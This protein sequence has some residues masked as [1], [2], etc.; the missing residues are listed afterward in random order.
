MFTGKNKEDL[1]YRTLG[2]VGFLNYSIYENGVIVNLNTG[3]ER[4][5]TKGTRYPMVTLYNRGKVKTFSIHRLLALM[6]ID[7]PDNL[8]C[9][10]HLDDNKYNYDLSNLAWGTHAE[11][12]KDAYDSGVKKYHNK[13]MPKGTNHG[14]A[15]LNEVSVNAIRLIYSESDT[16]MNELSE[17]YN[18]GR[19][20][21]GDIINRKTWKHC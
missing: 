16:T 11:N 14:L 21:I 15:K 10:K 13:P 4:S 18:V 2:S 19:R 12:N 7:N 1:K 9:V 8:P 17:R 6:F 20:T 5:I 3:K